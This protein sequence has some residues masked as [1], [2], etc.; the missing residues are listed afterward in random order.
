MLLEAF[1]GGKGGAFSSFSESSPDG[2]FLVELLLTT[3][4]LLLELLMTERAVAPFLH[5]NDDFG[6]G[7][8]SVGAPSMLEREMLVWVAKLPF[9]LCVVV[10]GG[11]GGNGVCVAY[12]LSD[13]FVLYCSCGVLRDSCG[14]PGGLC[15]GF[16]D[17]VLLNACSDD[18]CILKSPS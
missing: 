1:R 5:A 3:E 16:L 6:A 9:M 2:A 18:V 17:K 11:N 13:E 7:V 8:T 14:E 12:R 10:G 4:A 15:F